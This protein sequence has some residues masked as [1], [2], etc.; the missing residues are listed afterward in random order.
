ML[1]QCLFASTLSKYITKQT[2]KVV[3]FTSRD[4]TRSF[5]S[6]FS[7]TSGPLKGKS[8]FLSRLLGSSAKKE[9]ITFSR[10]TKPW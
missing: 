4:C 1:F 10:G 2:F 8:Y 3:E 6:Q 5:S 7:T 9:I